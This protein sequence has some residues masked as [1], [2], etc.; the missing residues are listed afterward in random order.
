MALSPLKS[1]MRRKAHDRAMGTIPSSV[2]RAQPLMR[3]EVREVPASQ[4]S[5][6]GGNWFRI[7]GWE[8]TGC[9]DALS[10]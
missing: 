10:D 9:G 1:A 7:Q 2:M 8:S 6:N 4:D 5:F 3:R